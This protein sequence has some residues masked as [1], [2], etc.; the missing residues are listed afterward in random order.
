MNPRRR[1]FQRMRRKRQKLHAEIAQL[2]NSPWLDAIE[3][4][5]EEQRATEWGNE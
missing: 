4:W 3:R 5:I 2:I 1:R